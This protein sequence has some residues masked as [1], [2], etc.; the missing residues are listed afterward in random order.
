MNNLKSKKIKPLRLITL[1]MYNKDDTMSIIQIIEL[2]INSILTLIPVLT[3]LSK[4]IPFL[5]SYLKEH[6]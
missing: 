3:D 5:L 4:L 1:K 6:F 2:I